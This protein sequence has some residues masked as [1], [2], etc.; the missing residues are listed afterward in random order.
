MKQLLKLHSQHQI[1]IR[2][3]VARLETM[4]D[5][6]NVKRLINHNHGYRLRVGDYRVLRLG[7]RYQNRQCSGGR[8]T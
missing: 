8:E 5:V 4:P 1:Q 7:I 2:D 3:A 6:I